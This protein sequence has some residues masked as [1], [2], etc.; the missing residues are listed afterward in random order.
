MSTRF[1]KV[2]AL[3]RHSSKDVRSIRLQRS[4]LERPQFLAAQHL[5]ARVLIGLLMLRAFAGP[6]IATCTVLAIGM[7]IMIVTAFWDAWSAAIDKRAAPDTCRH[8]QRGLIERIATS[9]SGERFYQCGACGAFYRRWSRADPYVDASGPDFLAVSPKA[10]SSAGCEAV[11]HPREGSFDW[12]RTVSTLCQNK[13]RRQ[14]TPRVAH[15]GTKTL[16]SG[17]RQSSPAI[18]LTRYRDPL[19]DL[20]L[21]GGSLGSSAAAQS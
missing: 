12:T 14:L 1:Q 9:A 13:R 18:H 21:D 7:S 3:M 17:V 8:C 19:W 15:G 20:Q 11:T 5:F 6:N 2:L 10:P 4:R 16:S